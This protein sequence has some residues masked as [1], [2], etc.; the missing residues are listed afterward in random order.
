[1]R[2]RAI[3]GIGL[4]CLL[5]GCAHDGGRAPGGMAWSLHH[6]EG[7]GAKL[8]YGQPASDNVLLMM[9]CEPRSGRVLVSLTAPAGQARPAIELSSKRQTTRLT[10]AVT[11]GLGDNAVFVEA[12]A[13][14]SDPAL[15]SFAKTGD[16]AVVEQGREARLPVRRVERAAVSNFFDQCSA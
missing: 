2:R 11:P 5:A 8:A 7:E 4:S 10:G 14:A 15:Q 16:I 6:A 12:Q 9:T 3:I 13:R 1:M